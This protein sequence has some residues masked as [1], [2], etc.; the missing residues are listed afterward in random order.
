[1]SEQTGIGWT[2]ATWNPWIGCI[3]VSPG[4]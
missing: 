1:M 2:D 4:V 3:K